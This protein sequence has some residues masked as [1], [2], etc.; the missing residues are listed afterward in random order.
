MS[1]NNG[2]TYL[3][4]TGDEELLARLI[5][6]LRKRGIEEHR[7]SVLS[8]IPYHASAFGL[9]EPDVPLQW[10]TIL[11]G[12]LGCLGG[13]LLTFGTTYLYPLKTGSLPV[14]SIPPYGII[15]YEGTMLLALVTTIACFGSFLLW[16]RWVGGR[17]LY[18]PRIQEGKLGLLVH[19]PD[20]DPG[21]R[22][23]SRLDRPPILDVVRREG[24]HR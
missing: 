1:G 4:L 14:Y 3:A 19:C 7:L 9:D 21:D 24:D 8:S 22:V 20:G 5:R 6:D 23:R 10:F 11:G 2:V 16:R 17:R 13:G 18:D 12:V 15:A